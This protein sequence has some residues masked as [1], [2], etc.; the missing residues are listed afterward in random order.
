MHLLD[1]SSISFKLQDHPDTLYTISSLQGMTLVFT[2]STQRNKSRRFHRNT[3]NRTVTPIHTLVS[4]IS[5]INSID[6]NSSMS[7][8]FNCYKGSKSL[9]VE[10]FRS[11][12]SFISN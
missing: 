8:N 5:C 10:C 12:N 1:S 3:A 2:L 11:S 9:N 4:K 6:F 7:I